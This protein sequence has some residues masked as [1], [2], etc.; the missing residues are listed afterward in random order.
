MKRSK[1]KILQMVKNHVQSVDPSAEVMLYGS[2]ARNEEHEESDWDLLVLTNRN[3]SIADEK[4][5]RSKIYDLELELG[6]PF[7]TIIYNKEVWKS[8]MKITPFYEN[9]MKEG[10]PL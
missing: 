7:S 8:K 4:A 1:Q 9:V 2:R 5:Y 10:S 6:E 3:I